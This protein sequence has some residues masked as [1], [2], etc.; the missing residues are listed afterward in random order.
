M[1]VFFGEV[2]INAENRSVTVGASTGTITTGTYYG[3]S[4]V[5]AESACYWLAAQLTTLGAVAVTAVVSSDGLL[6]VRTVSTA[7]VITGFEA[8]DLF[9]FDADHFT[10]ADTGHGFYSYT[11]TKRI[12]GS[13]VPGTEPADSLCPVTSHGVSTPL[14]AQDQGA[15]GT[16]YTSTF[17][18]LV[19]QSL[20]FEYVTKAGAWNV[21]STRS[22]VE[23]FYDTCDDGR[24]V[25]YIPEW[26]GS[27]GS[28]T[29]YWDYVIDLKKTPETPAKRQRKSTDI[30]WIVTLELLGV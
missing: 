13:W 26:A 29:A 23:E 24:R 14:T 18:A 7:L 16:A 5:N 9:G 1:S 4:P 21:D 25:L 2:V 12:Y 27:G 19:R 10:L 8:Y 20:T 3:W 22:S 17:G 15:D 6:S 30:F 28:Y 11:A